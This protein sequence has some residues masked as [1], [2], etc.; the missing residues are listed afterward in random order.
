[1]GL[2]LP[3]FSD[4]GLKART[5]QA[6]TKDLKLERSF[7]AI[8]GVIERNF[9]IIARSFRYFFLISSK[10]TGFFGV[11]QTHPHA[12]AGIV[13]LIQTASKGLR[14]LWFREPLPIPR[15]SKIAVCP[16]GPSDCKS[17]YHSL[18]TRPAFESRRGFQ[19]EGSCRVDKGRFFWGVGV[20]PDRPLSPHT[21]H[22]SQTV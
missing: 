19:C 13:V 15:F 11:S 8:S 1:M 12:I 22:P 21:P 6:S 3:D 5:A 9:A 7:L 17:S 16:L 14:P 18:T 4:L 2:Q 20:S 10:S